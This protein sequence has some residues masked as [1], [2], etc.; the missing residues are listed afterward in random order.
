[1]Q[2]EHPGRPPP[3]A[4]DQREPESALDANRRLDVL[5]PVV[6]LQGQVPKL[7]GALLRHLIT[8]AWE[9]IRPRSSQPEVVRGDRLTSCIDPSGRKGTKVGTCVTT[10]T[11]SPQ[12]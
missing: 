12:I 7:S 5:V 9:P 6:G 1:M 4:V 10:S 3:G 11:F 8:P 2:G